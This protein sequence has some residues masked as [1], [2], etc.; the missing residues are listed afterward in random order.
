MLPGL[1]LNRQ[2]AVMPKKVEV[3]APNSPAPV[4]PR[5]LK[6]PVLVVQGIGA[7]LPAAKTGLMV[8]PP[9]DVSYK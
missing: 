4:S 6:P 8:Q 7:P 2:L 1:P 3:A 5:P 9:S